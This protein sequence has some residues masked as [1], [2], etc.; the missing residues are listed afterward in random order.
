MQSDSAQTTIT[1]QPGSPA[2]DRCSLCNQPIAATYYRLNEKMACPAC[3]NKARAVRASD[4]PAAYVRALTAGFG[5]AVAGMLAY[6]LIAIILRGWVISLMAVAVGFMVGAAMMK[7]SKAVGGRRYQITAALLT[8]AAVSTAAIPIWIYFANQHRTQLTERQKLQAE[9][10]EL[11]QENGQASQE[12]QPPPSQPSGS[13]AR[14][15]AV[16]GRLAMLGLLSPFLQLEN[17][18]LWGGMG[19][20]I[21]FFG[22]RTTWTITAGRP[23]E[24]YGPFDNIP[25]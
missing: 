6:A 17:D 14:I 19:L 25:R 4:A 12:P 15:G 3:L 2:T 23:F 5:A 13:L 20:V 11:E 18:P 8:Y 1:A 7:A 21:L 16:A 10:R 24:V 9:Q 22:I